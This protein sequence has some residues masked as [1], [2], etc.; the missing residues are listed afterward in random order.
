MA[1]KNSTS[2]SGEDFIVS[3]YQ[4]LNKKALIMFH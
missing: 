4:E 1:W 2:T 3:I